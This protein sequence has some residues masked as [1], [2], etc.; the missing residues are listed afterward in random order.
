M[1]LCIDV[2]N[3]IDIVSCTNNN[4][5]EVKRGKLKNRDNT[6]NKFYDYPLP[7]SQHASY[8]TTKFQ[9]LYSYM[10]IEKRE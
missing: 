7:L 10:N 1:K 4:N 2:C 3:Q 5:I 9:L 6:T 8:K